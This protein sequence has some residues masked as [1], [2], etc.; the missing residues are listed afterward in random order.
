MFTS[1]KIC[2]IIRLLCCSLEIQMAIITDRFNVSTKGF[3]DIVDIT[4]QIVE[5][6]KKHEIQNSYYMAD[7]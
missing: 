2:V 5:L 7:P 4:S 3:T 1:K 6:T